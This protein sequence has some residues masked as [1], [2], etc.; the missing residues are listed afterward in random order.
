MTKPFEYDPEKQPE[1]EPDSVPTPEPFAQPVDNK[2]AGIPAQMIQLH[3]TGVMTLPS[4]APPGGS[5]A[6]W[7]DP[8][9]SNRVKYVP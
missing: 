7:Y 1:P 4:V 9:D 6:M 3:D 5:K 2:V 8:A